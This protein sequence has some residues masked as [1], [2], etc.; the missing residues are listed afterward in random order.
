MMDVDD[1]NKTD[2]L[3]QTIVIYTMGK[4]MFKQNSGLYLISYW[5][6]TIP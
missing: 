4:K 5:T 1:I 6:K 3:G 2:N